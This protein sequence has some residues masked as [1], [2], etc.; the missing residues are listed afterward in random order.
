MTTTRVLLCLL[1][2]STAWAVNDPSTDPN[3]VAWYTFT[4]ADPFGDKSGNG[5]DLNGQGGMR[6][7]TTTYKEGSSAAAFAAAGL[8]NVFE[9]DTNLS[10]DFPARGTDSNP[11]FSVTGWFNVETA[12]DNQA[13]VAKYNHS[14]NERCWGIH[15]YPTSNHVWV[16]W[17]HNNGFSVESYTCSVTNNIDTGQWYFFHVVFDDPNNACDIRI[18]DATE[19]FWDS[20]DNV[21][22]DLMN[23]EN[24]AFYL[25]RQGGGNYLDGV[26]DEVAIFSKDLT[27]T[28]ANTIVAGTYDYSADPNCISHWSFEADGLGIDELGNNH[29]PSP[30]LADQ[31]GPNG[32][33]KSLRIY[34]AFSGDRNSAVWCDDALLSS[35]FPGKNGQ[36]NDVLSVCYWVYHDNLDHH[37]TSPV[38]PVGKWM[39]EEGGGQ[40][41]D[42]RSF[43]EGTS[44]EFK[45]SWYTG[46]V[47]E[48]GLIAGLDK[49]YHVVAIMSDPN[50][51]TDLAVWDATGETR[52]DST[53][54]DAAAMGHT[55]VV[56]GLGG[57][58]TQDDG[59]L[60]DWVDGNQ[61]MDGFIGEVIVFNRELT[62]PEIDEIRNGEFDAAAA[63]GQIMPVVFQ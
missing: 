62:D 27:D 44:D 29:L 10:A 33:V 30:G 25:G 51:S 52:Y 41:S 14:T 43:L 3:C 61:S 11:T 12:S 39:R 8:S 13:L 18:Y 20:S 49:W 9:S 38:V 2:C 50:N 47:A 60:Y 48:S 16:G 35:N 24:V 45:A 58:V 6:R 1:L 55:T 42:W 17:G 59:T 15:A 31:A 4:G 21:P 56:F 40:P 32:D 57:R 63:S 28:D 53:G 34:G 22:T 7:D 46:A 54:T 23:C 19:D 36:T 37:P 26:L 5:N